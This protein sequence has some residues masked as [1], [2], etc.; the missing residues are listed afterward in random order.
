MKRVFDVMASGC[1]LL[2]LSPVFLILAV[3]VK[4]DSRGPI[5]YRQARVGRFGRDFMLYKFRTMR[6]GSDKKGLI[7]IGGR[8]PRAVSYTHL[9]LPTN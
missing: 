7:T 6:V 3:V 5:F 9:T 2:V 8:D 4:L 1:G